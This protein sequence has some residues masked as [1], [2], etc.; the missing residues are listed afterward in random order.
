MGFTIFVVKGALIY[1]LDERPVD[2]KKWTELE[3]V[4][5]YFEFF[6]KHKNEF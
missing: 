2:I 4:R 3:G 5:T 6:E 1:D